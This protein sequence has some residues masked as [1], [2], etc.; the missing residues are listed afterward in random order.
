[1]VPFISSLIFHKSLVHSSFERTP[2]TL[3]PVFFCWT[4]HNIAIIY[5]STLK[6]RASVHCSTCI[7][8]WIANTSPLTDHSY[9][10]III[11]ILFSREHPVHAHD[12]LCY[13]WNAF[14]L[15]SSNYCSQKTHCALSVCFTFETNFADNVVSSFLVIQ[16][17]PCSC[18]CCLAILYETAHASFY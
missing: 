7:A 11:V 5:L 2:Y 1:M 3:T 13:T 17:D 10:N 8:F 12:L 4:T 16:I 9:Y 6:Q 15:S 18:S 14:L